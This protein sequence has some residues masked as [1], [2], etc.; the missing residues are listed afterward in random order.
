[1]LGWCYGSMKATIAVNAARVREPSGS[2]Q[3]L[4]RIAERHPEVLL[5][6]AA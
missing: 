4:L 3:T 5:E 1:M 2:A 6:V